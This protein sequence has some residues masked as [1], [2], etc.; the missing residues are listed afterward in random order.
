MR[1]KEK[2]KE[3]EKKRERENN[4]CF[5]VVAP[6][7]FMCRLEFLAKHLPVFVTL[8]VLGN[9][10]TE[11]N[12]KAPCELSASLC[13]DGFVVGLIPFVFLTPPGRRLEGLFEAFRRPSESLPFSS[14][15]VSH[16]G[17]DFSSIVRLAQEDADTTP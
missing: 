5:F 8:C 17:G 7:W 2:H 3:K 6:P 1:E 11:S 10:D 4:L 15:C 13:R 9:I 14:L 16:W 12:R